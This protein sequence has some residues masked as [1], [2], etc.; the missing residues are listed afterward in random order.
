MFG[1]LSKADQAEVWKP[2]IAVT[3]LMV[4]AGCRRAKCWACDSLRSICPD[5]LRRPA[6]RTAGDTPYTTL[7]CR[8]GWS[9]VI[10]HGLDDAFLGWLWNSHE[11]LEIAVM[12]RHCQQQ[13][14]QPVGDRAPLF[15]LL[16][17]PIADVP[18]C[19]R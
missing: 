16:A 8:C 4:L 13:M 17:C 14:S 3:W 12:Q 15:R 10:E 11:P 6:H 9:E 19:G 7:S 2:A 5:E 1:T 18:I